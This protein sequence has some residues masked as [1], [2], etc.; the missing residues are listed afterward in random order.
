MILNIRVDHKTADISKMERSSQKLDIL[1]NNIL[2]MYQVNEYLKIKTCN[3]VEIYLVLEECNIENLR[4]N[5]FVIESDDNAMRHLLRLSSGLE[6]MIIG[7]DQILGQIKDAKKKGI[8]EGCS[9]QVLQTIFTKAVHVGQVVRK[10]TKINE[11][12]LSIGSAAVELAESVHGDLKCKKVLIIGAGK[13]GTLVA[14]ALVEKKLKAIVVANRTHDKAVLLAKELKGSAIHFD[15]LD[16]AL[17]DA[18]VVIS[19]T[20]APHPI[21]TYEKLKDV[22]PDFNI[23]KMVMVDIANPRDIEEDVS[24]LGVKLFNIDDLRGIAN[25]SRKM[26]E[27]E[28]CDAEKIVAGEMVLLKRSL[29]HLEVE[30]VI[31][32]IR[33]T[34]ENIRLNET[35][36]AFKM[37]GDMNGNEKIVDDL[38]KV[39]VERLFF[40]VI[41]NIKEAAENDE[42]NVIEAAETIF[43]KKS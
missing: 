39:V 27:T 25:R 3:R 9:G 8:Q 10:K 26:R 41:K 36:K 15:K 12:S 31:S 43:S 29:K 4:S 17:I 34:A 24:K 30:P 22:V 16:E 6:S 7:E 42:K 2:E 20:G 37:L 19:A 14:K 18:D 33:I 23:S 38:T 21:L 1:F 11:G 5:D 13:M 40:N 28:A 32:N 35:Q